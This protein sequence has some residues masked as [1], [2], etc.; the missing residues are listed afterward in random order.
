[1]IKNLFESFYSRLALVVLLS[2]V[3]VGIFTATLFNKSSQAQQNEIAQKL[4]RH[5]AAHVVKENTL[6]VDGVFDSGAM[7]MVFMNLMVMGPN[8]E[9]YLLDDKGSVLAYSAEPGKVK[10]DTVDLKPIRN[11]LSDSNAQQTIYGTDPRAEH[12]EKIFSAAPIV[13]DNELKGYLY[14]IIGGETYDDIA[15][16]VQGSEIYRWIMWSLAGGILLTFLVT[17]FIVKLLTKP[18]QHLNQDVQAF[19]SS[20]LDR[21]K[22]AISHWPSNSKH[23]INQL[24]SAFENMAYQLIEQYKKVKDTDELRR[25][26][27]SHVSHDLR[28]PLASLMGYLETWQM[29][30]SELSPEQSREF[31]STA[32]KN[33]QIISQL[34]EQLFELA[35]LDSGDVEVHYEAISIA[36]LVQDVLQK[37]SLEAEQREVTLDVSPKDPALM[38]MAD[39]EK[40]DRVFTNLVGNA[41]RHCKPGDHITINLANETK[42]V[43]VQVKDSGIGIPRS[44]LPYIFN[45]HFKAANSVRGNNAHG[46]L[47]LA[48][49]K[50][51]LALHNT[52]IRVNSVENQGTEFDFFLLASA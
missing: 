9:F 5:L 10:Q 26:L 39:I 44:D 42:R 34:I 31:V 22:L 23:E 50:K 11:F 14:V 45:A 52:T 33:A 43:L 49:T 21:D 24:G 20:G 3:L 47:G 32:H 8:F 7:K 13:K 25:E 37:F 4:H 51:L 17:L 48:I 40:L 6:F 35:H 29:K 18:L 30:Q 2:F 46:G 16:M 28:T 41:L 36:E 38:V 12:R 27:M 1:M 15:Q 19:R